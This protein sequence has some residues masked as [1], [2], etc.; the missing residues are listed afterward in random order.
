MMGNAKFDIVISNPPYIKERDNAPTFEPV[1]K[2][3]F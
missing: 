2:S 3:N 1:N